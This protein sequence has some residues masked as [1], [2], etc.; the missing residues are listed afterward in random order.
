MDVGDH[1]LELF[2]K[3]S[4]WALDSARRA[5]WPVQGGSHARRARCDAAKRNLPGAFPGAAQLPGSLFFTCIAS[6]PL[7]ACS[8]LVN[9]LLLLLLLQRRLLTSRL[10]HSQD[11]AARIKVPRTS[12]QPAPVPSPVPPEQPTPSST[13]SHFL[14]TCSPWPTSSAASTTGCCVYSGMSALSVC[15][16][17]H[18][19][20]ARTHT[21]PRTH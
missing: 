10:V 7:R 20:C 21:H 9:S 4:A 19:A 3:C 13:P 1:G 14:P 16:S 18:L 2:C 17:S 12:H 15:L 6:Q 8:R 5:G 11:P